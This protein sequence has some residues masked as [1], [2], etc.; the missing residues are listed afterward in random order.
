[1]HA[2]M[3]GTVYPTF[4]LWPG[5]GHNGTCDEDRIAERESHMKKQSSLEQPSEAEDPR[6][7]KIICRFALLAQRAREARKRKGENLYL[8]RLF[9]W[10]P[11]FIVERST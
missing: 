10:N 9:E 4:V 5:N 8:S 2:G 1:M 11:R 3:L 6:A 7:E